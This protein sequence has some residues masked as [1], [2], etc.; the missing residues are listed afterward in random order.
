M[1]PFKIK[2]FA[3]G[4]ELEAMLALYR[5]SLIAGFTTNPTL[6]RKAG[7]TDYA[8]FARQVIAAIPDRPVSFE[9]F[10]DDIDD[11]IMQG[12]EIARWGANVNVKIPVTTTTGEY[13]GRV[14]ETL[15][16]RGIMLNVTAI[17]TLA[18]V[19]QVA[20]SLRGEA[21]HI[22]SVFAGR[23][24]DTGIDPVPHMVACREALR[25]IAPRAQLL[26]ASPRELLNVYHADEAGC[27]IITA[28]PDILAKLQLGGKDL[29]EYSLETV[30]MF[31]RDATAAGFK[32]DA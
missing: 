1:R 30:Q 16:D 29:A 22:V 6:M 7:I 23:I 28:T 32:I 17:M 10:A 3:D 4:A 18:Q 20:R 19:E 31:Y 21:P 5:N 26:W 13:T 11:M 27:D 15:S 14:I 9:V 24:A 8:G 25:A 2:L 12:R